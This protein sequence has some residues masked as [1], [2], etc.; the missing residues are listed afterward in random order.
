[1]ELYLR[2]PIRLLGVV[3][4]ELCRETQLYLLPLGETANTVE[5]LRQYMPFEFSIQAIIRFEVLTV[6]CDVTP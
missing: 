1:V 2:S 6:F 5:L 4:N 3:L